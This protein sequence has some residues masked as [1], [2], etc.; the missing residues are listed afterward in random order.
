MI[1]YSKIV[2]HQQFGFNCWNGSG[3]A[4]SSKV[5]I[6]LIV[7][8]CLYFD[9]QLNLENSILFETFGIDVIEDNC[10]SFR[11]DLDDNDNED[12]MK[13]EEKL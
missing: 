6:V 13:D 7:T 3:L 8:G 9:G 4:I 10:S 1:V 2:F 11:E 5:R 12:D